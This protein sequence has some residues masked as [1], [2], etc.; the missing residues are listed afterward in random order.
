MSFSIFNFNISDINL[1]LLQNIV[2]IEQ[3][4]IKTYFYDALS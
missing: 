1:S 4:E 3:V 2:I